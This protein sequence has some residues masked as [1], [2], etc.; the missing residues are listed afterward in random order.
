MILQAPVV[1]CDAPC[2]KRNALM[3]SAE[4]EG[5]AI[6]R[7]VLGIVPQDLCPDH[8]RVD[9]TQPAGEFSAALSK[10]EWGIVFGALDYIDMNVQVDDFGSVRSKLSEQ[11]R[12]T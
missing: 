6:N 1:V 11:L 10:T 3:T 12:S 4:R 5:W 7:T 2:C 9:A 8:A